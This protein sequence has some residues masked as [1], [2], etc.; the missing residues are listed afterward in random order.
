MRRAYY[1]SV[2][3]ILRCQ[4]L[5][6]Q[7]LQKGATRADNGGVRLDWGPFR[8]R[9][10]GFGHVLLIG[11]GLDGPG[12]WR[13][14]LLRLVGLS[15]CSFDL[16]LPLLEDLNQSVA[17]RMGLNLGAYPFVGAGRFVWISLIMIA[18][19]PT[20]HGLPWQWD[21]ILPWDLRCLDAQ[22]RRRSNDAKATSLT[23]TFYNAIASL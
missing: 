5:G 1:P 18:R 12:L 8:R 15:G 2:L 16:S 14:K 19:L 13:S 23:D 7:G 11:F 10:R 9:D 21:Q 4:D 17:L 22:T 3:C 6:Y 20:E